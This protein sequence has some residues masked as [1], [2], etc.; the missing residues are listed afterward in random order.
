[1]ANQFV[2]LLVSKIYSN[3]IS[4]HLLTTSVQRN[5]S[6]PRNADSLRVLQLTYVGCSLSVLH[7]LLLELMCIGVA[8]L[9]GTTNAGTVSN[10]SF[11]L[12]QFHLQIRP[13]QII[14]CDAEVA[15][16]H[17]IATMIEY[18]ANNNRGYRLADPG[19]VSPGFSQAMAGDHAVYSHRRGRIVDNPPCLH[20][21]DGDS[22]PV[23]ENVLGISA[24]KV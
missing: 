19:V 8:Q 15:A 13:V 4:E 6:T 20:P 9:T 12:K 7:N 17:L 11:L 14:L 21:A 3:T 1:M 16:G 2:A 22:L 5:K 24:G 23:T 10:H 18:I